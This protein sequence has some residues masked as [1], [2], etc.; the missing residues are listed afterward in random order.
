MPARFETVE[1]L[2]DFMTTPSPALTQDL[3]HVDGDILVLGVGGK[4]GPSY[5]FV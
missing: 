3:A 1:V 2:E 5:N 4:M